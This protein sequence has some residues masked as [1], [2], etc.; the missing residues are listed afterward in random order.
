MHGKTH[1]S[2]NLTSIPTLNQISIRDRTLCPD[3]VTC[4]QNCA[5]DG[6]DYAGT[7]GITTSGNS[8]TL[9][10]SSAAAT[11]SSGVGSRV[12]LL[13]TDAKYKLFNPLNREIAFDVNVSNL[14]CGVN[15]ALYFAQVSDYYCKLRYHYID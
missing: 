3:P 12:F 1:V 8:I 5:L 6:A 11:A 10:L 14:P 4:A 9:K 2:E 13:D 7:Y 15:G